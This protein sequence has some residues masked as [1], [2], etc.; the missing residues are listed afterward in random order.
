[1]FLSVVQKEI[2]SRFPHVFEKQMKTR[3]T[4]SKST[5]S[6]TNYEVAKLGVVTEKARQRNSLRLDLGVLEPKHSLLQ[7]WVRGG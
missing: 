2:I 6:D 5:C 3:Y 4:K 1:M 7:R